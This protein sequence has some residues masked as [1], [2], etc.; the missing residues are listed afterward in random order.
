M[1]SFTRWCVKHRP[2]P[3]THPSFWGGGGG[4]VAV[5]VVGVN[6]PDKRCCWLEH[7]SVAIRRYGS[8]GEG[9]GDRDAG[10]RGCW[11]D[12][13]PLPHSSSGNVSTVRSRP[14][15]TFADDPGTGSTVIH[16]SLSRSVW[17]GENNNYSKSWI[18][19]YDSGE[20]STNK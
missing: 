17:Q 13:E 11:V 4:A 7:E 2:T 6:T 5:A 19:Y 9:R 3:Q 16:S 8:S 10:L 14:F 1:L 15:L 12:A 20:M 18:D